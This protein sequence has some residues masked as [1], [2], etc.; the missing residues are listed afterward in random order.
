MSATA[1]GDLGA[2]EP[3]SLS[4]AEAELGAPPPVAGAAAIRGS[5]AQRL[6]SLI[7]LSRS[8]GGRKV[9][10]ASS[11]SATGYAVT[12]LLR[13]VS[14]IT[15]AKLLSNAAPMG[16][17]TIIAVILAGLELLCDL[18][19]GVGIVQHKEGESRDYL[20]TAFSVQA[21]RGGLLGIIAAALAFP[22]A[23][24]YH[25]PALAPLL[26]FGALSLLFRSF[27]NPRMWLYTRNVSLRRPATLTIASEVVGF[28]V[29]IVW[30]VMAPSA[31]AIVGGTVAASLA[32]AIVSHL[33][34]PPIRFGWNKAMAREIVHFG[35]WMLLSSAT[36]FLSSRGENLILKGAIPDI[37]FGCF[38][39]ASMIVST[40]VTAISQ[41]AS[42]VFL[43]MLAAS[44]REDRER[45][46]RQ[47]ARGKWAFTGLALC[48]AWGAIFV[49]PPILSMFKL[50]R[51]F[52]DLTWMVPLLGVR[53]AL[54]ILVAPTGSVLIASGGSRFNSMANVTRMIVLVVGLLVTVHQWGLPGAIVVLVGA[55]AFSYFAYLPGLPSRIPGGLRVDLMSVAVF[56]T[57]AIGALILHFGLHLK[58]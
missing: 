13:F 47:F 55:P 36:Y 3:S 6:A 24:T 48:F 38:A 30:A 44:V 16:D 53:A 57:G 4:E 2:D 34:A 14:R 33:L 21:L 54:D 41:L 35:G 51:G 1:K 26:V 5:I 19:I 7:T 56:W 17:V 23:W 50:P 52:G 39:F 49:G 46:S 10:K 22:I 32:F 58:L 37:E 8:K 15:L 45:A 25:D 9:F 27:S 12:T 20:D 18:G 42:Q 28:L 29:T 43:P 31:W 40:P 11:W